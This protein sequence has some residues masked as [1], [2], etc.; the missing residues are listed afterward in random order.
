MYVG[1]TPDGY[2]LFSVQMTDAQWRP[3]AP[4]VTEPTPERV[5]RH[6]AS[7]TRNTIKNLLSAPDHR[8]AFLDADARI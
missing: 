3:V 7:F 1:Y 6:H 2:D 4:Q 8:A 5:E